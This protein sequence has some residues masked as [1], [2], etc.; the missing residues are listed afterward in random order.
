[1]FWGLNGSGKTSLLKILHSAL[2]SNAEP[3][4]RLPFTK[5]QVDIYSAKYD[6]IIRRTINRDPK[7]EEEISDP[8]DET[9]LTDELWTVVESAEL[10]AMRN[11]QER[12]FR[13]RT[14]V[15]TGT[16]IL[17]LGRFQHGYLPISRVAESRGMPINRPSPH[18]EAMGDAMFDAMF[19]RQVT[20]RSQLYTSGASAQIREIQQQGLAEILLVLFGGAQKTRQRTEHDIDAGPAFRLVTSFLRQQGIRVNFDIESFTS[21]YGKQKELR[22]IV[23]KIQEVMADINSA[24]E[25]QRDFEKLIGE[26]FSGNKTVAFEPRGLRV[27]VNDEKIPLE[28]L[29]SGE[30]QLMQ[31]LLEVMAGG[32]NAVIIDEPELSMHVDWQNRLVASMRTVNPESQLVLATHS[33]EVMANLDEKYI[34]QL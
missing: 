22:D 27:M 15:L 7:T 33:P 4:A 25:P 30:K 13:W 20:R 31:I 12:P 26:L 9:L 19:A 14:I 10:A 17:P 34:F 2:Q 16:A 11:D 5:A 6:S 8:E 21:R 23:D 28:S 3:I 18:G 1:V 24:L 29:S 32:V